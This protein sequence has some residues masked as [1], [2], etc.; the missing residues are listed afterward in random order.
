VCGKERLSMVTDVIEVK[1]GGKG[2]EAG[3]LCS[4]PPNT[5]QGRAQEFAQ[6]FCDV[7]GSCICVSVMG[8]LGLF[9]GDGV[10]S[11]FVTVHC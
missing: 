9:F 10:G 3:G 8:E 4:L 5:P 6:C 11:V 2:K 7:L 1:A